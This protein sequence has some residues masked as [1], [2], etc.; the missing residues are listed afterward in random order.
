MMYVDYSN[1]NSLAQAMRGVQHVVLVIGF[2]T[3]RVDMCKKMIQR[4]QKSG[5]KSI[6]M[7]SHM[8][9]MSS[10]HQSLK[11]F[12]EIEEEMFSTDMD[13]V[14]LRHEKVLPRDYSSNKY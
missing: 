2:E 6:I 9:A 13:T 3:N 7:V 4:A 5:V 11:E 10:T 12:S 1:E 8:G 14:I